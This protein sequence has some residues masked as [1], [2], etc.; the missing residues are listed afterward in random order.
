MTESNNSNNNKT[1]S[2]AGRIISNSGINTSD[3]N[4]QKEQVNTQTIPSIEENMAGKMIIKCWNCQNIHIV[5]N[6]WKVVQCPI[7]HEI[8]KVPQQ[9]NEVQE[10]LKYLK[11]ATV[12]SY[13]D[14]EHKVPLVNYLVVCPY[15]KTD[16]QVRET[17]FHCICYKCKNRW[18][19]QRPERLKEKE[20]SLKSPP[21][22][23]ENEG[24]YYKYDSKTGMVYP[25]DKPLRFS[26]L[27][28]PDPTFYPGYYPIN[29]LSPL[30]PEYFNPYDDYRYVDRQ[31]KM[32]KYNNRIQKERQSKLNNGLD[33]DKYT[34]LNKLNEIEKK[35]DKMME[36]RIV[37]LKNEYG[38]YNKGS[39]SKS[40][41]KVKSYENMFFMK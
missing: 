32:L 4:D 15:C 39:T 37:P 40:Y 41:D 33:I 9:L 29:S 3:G 24:N 7:C 36:N 1:I 22:K 20:D 31:M 14:K 11:A 17:A 5:K 16:N 28:Y 25:P 18:A 35:A 19:I 38:V 2:N 34:I 30:Y 26:D 13:A 23:P 27:F 8:N 6:S 21:D 10:L 12:I